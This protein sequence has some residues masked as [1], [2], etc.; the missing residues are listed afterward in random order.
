MLKII[1]T[2]VWLGIEFAKPH[3]VSDGTLP[4]FMTA[5][6]KIGIK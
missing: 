5:I 6:D 2:P 4:F 1:E 3:P